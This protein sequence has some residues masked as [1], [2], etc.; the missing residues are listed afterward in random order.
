MNNIP[1]SIISKL[2]MYSR[3][4]VRRC[5]EMRLCQAGCLSLTYS[6]HWRMWVV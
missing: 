5:K 6:K 2:F 4:Y 1:I 3:V